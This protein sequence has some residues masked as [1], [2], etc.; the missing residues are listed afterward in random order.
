V[1]RPLRYDGGRVE[2]SL[3]ES[4]MLALRAEA[5]ALGVTPG[6]L[7]RSLVDQH[8]TG[9]ARKEGRPDAA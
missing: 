2:I 8:V 5:R 1:A 6:D 3:S 9:L 7:L 4:Q